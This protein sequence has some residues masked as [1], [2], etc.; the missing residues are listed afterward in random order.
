MIEV[1]SAFTLPIA[2]ERIFE[3]LGDVETVIRCIPGARMLGAVDNRNALCQARVLFGKASISYRGSVHVTG[4]D[5]EAH[6][7]S[8]R[9][10]GNEVRGTGSVEAI[11]DVRL[12]ESAGVTTASVKGDAFIS[13]RA[14]VLRTDVVQRAAESLLHRFG[15]ALGAHIESMATAPVAHSKHRS[16]AATQSPAHTPRAVARHPVP[17]GEAAQRREPVPRVPD[18]LEDFPP[19]SAD[20]NGSHRRIPGRIEVVTDEPVVVSEDPSESPMDRVAAVVQENPWMVPAVL[21]ALF[22]FILLGRRRGRAD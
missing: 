8:F 17:S 2:A 21:M 4:D 9:I 14:A 1:A 11:V 3:V 13:G 6:V 12:R 16:A 7:I 15:A 19:R 5:A 22:V 18:H 10:K 20:G